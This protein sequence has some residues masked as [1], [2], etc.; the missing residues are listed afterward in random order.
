MYIVLLVLVI[1]GKIWISLI[2]KEIVYEFLLA[3]LLIH[4]SKETIL[5]LIINFLFFFFP[6]LLMNIFTIFIK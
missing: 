2:E 1:M 5:T 4:E 3:I 6:I